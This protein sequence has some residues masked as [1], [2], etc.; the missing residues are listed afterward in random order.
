[1]V[2][3]PSALLFAFDVTLCDE[4]YLYNW[5]QRLNVVDNLHA[6]QLHFKEILLLYSLWLAAET[7]MGRF[8][9][10]WKRW[11]ISCKTGEMRHVGSVLF[12]SLPLFPLQTVILYWAMHLSLAHGVCVGWRCSPGSRAGACDQP[13]VD[14]CTTS[15][16]WWYVHGGHVTSTPEVSVPLVSVWPIWLEPDK[17]WGRQSCSSLAM[18][19]N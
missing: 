7:Y 13:G 8:L 5:T 10:L 17:I 14:Q 9:K 3:S 18:V 1:M 11:N 12:A 2:T 16:W 6:P 19:W 4:R 15:W